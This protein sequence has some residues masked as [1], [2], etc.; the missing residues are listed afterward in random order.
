M[1]VQIFLKLEEALALLNSFDSDASDV[2]IAV[3]PLDAREITDE[4]KRD[5]NE[6]NTAK[7]IVNDVPESVDVRTR[8]NS[9]S[10]PSTSYS[11]S[12]TENRKKL[13]DIS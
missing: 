3:L 7:I 9:Q 13:K 2:E 6:V 4:D 12:K 5:D 1:S 11:V 8:D 10:E